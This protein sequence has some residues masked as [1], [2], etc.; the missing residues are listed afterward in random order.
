MDDINSNLNEINVSQSFFTFL[1]TSK[2]ILISTNIFQILSSRVPEGERIINL[3]QESFT[4]SS[5][6]LPKNK[7]DDIMNEITNIRGEWDGVV[8]KIGDSL[9]NLK[10]NINRWNAMLENKKRLN[11]WL[12]EKEATLQSIPQGNGEISEMKTLLDRLKYLESEIAQK[13]SEIDDLNLEM[14]FFEPLG[15]PDEDKTKLQEIVER[16]KILKQNCGERMSEF[17]AEINDYMA[18][19]H[20]MQEIEKWLLQISFQLMAHNS[21]YISNYEQTKEQI[22]QHESL[23]DYIQK[24]QSNIDDLDA[25]GQQQIK[26]YEPFSSTVREKIEGQI[27]NIQESYNS[28][29]HTSIQIKNRL[30]D[31]LSKFK[32][33]E[34]TLDSILQNLDGFEKVV[35]MEM[36]KPLITLNEAKSQLQFM[37][38]MQNKLQ[39]E[40]Q[41]LVLACQAC[42]AA[43]ASISRPSSPVFN[44]SPQIPEK[45]LIVRAKLDDLV[46]KLL[47]CIDSLIHKVKEFD[48]VL[49]KRDD[50]NDWIEQKTIFAGDIASKPSKLRPES[51]AQD[52]QT[53]NDAI[54]SINQKRN[55]IVTEFTNQLPDEEIADL[56]KRLDDLESLLMNLIERKRNNQ[57]IID[58]YLKSISDTKSYFDGVVHRLEVIE[59]P[60]GKNCEQ[61]L[62]DIDT[63]KKEFETKAPQLRDQ[64][65]GKSSNVFEVISNLDAQ[66]VDDHLKAIQRR[67]NDIKKKIERKIQLMNLTNKNIEKLQSEIDQTKFFLEDNIL[68]LES[69]FVLGYISKPIEGYL[70]NLKNL[71]KDVENKQAFVESLNK[72]VANMHSE[73]DSNEQQKLKQNINEL[74]KKEKKLMD[75]LKAEN[76]RA[77]KG[78]N[79]AREVEN[80]IDI[81]RSWIADQK[82]YNESKA[83]I[84]SFSPSAIDYEVQE[85][86]KRLQDI[87]E[88][89]DSVLSDTIEQISIIKEQCDDSGKD[90]IQKILDNFLAEIQTLT[91]SYNQQLDTIQKILQ[92]KKEYE[93]DSEGLLNWIKEIEAIISSNVKTSSIQILEEQLRKYEA[94]LKEAESKEYVLK[95]VQEKADQLVEN[96]SEVDRLNLMCQV[97]NLSDKFNLLVLKLKERQNGIIDNIRQLKE[98]QK[99]ISEYTQFILSIQQAIRELN[100]PIGSKTEDVQNL[101]KEYENILNKLKAKKA[102]MSMQKISSLPQIKELLSTHDDIIEAIENQL[103]RLK[104]LLMLREQ[105]IALVNEI[106]NFNVKYTDIVAHV[107]KSDDKIENKIK[108]Y[109]KIMLKIQECEGL[110]ASAND[111]GMQIASEGTVEDRNNI[112]EQLQTLKQQLQNLKQTV[113]NLRQQYEKAANLYKN[114]E[115]DITKTINALH[116]KEAAIKILPIL[117]INSESV[118][119]E[120]RKHDVLAKDIQKL[121]VKLQTSID[122]IENPEA[123]PPS[124]AETVSIGRTLLRSLPK[125]VDERKKYLDNNRDYRLD[126]IKLVSEFKNWIDSVESEFVGDND[127]IDFENVDAIM[128]KHVSCVDNKL[129]DVKQLLEKINEVGKNILPSLN[130]INKEELLRDLQKFAATFKDI[131]ARAEQSKLNLEKNHDI[132]KSYCLLLQSIGQLLTKVSKE[133]AI[134]STDK[135]REFLQKLNT[136][137]ATIQV[138]S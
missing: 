126:Y 123:L 94:F 114:F 137:L 99:Q 135:L 42:E 122:G 125:E 52:M 47:P 73:L 100:K 84:V 8:L 82:A 56:E 48:E 20:Q 71:M 112:I 129:H 49:T 77:S 85:Y 96:L 39:H 104:Q 33:Y 87:K 105:F 76:S 11:N 25:K 14:K 110:F 60:C 95:A 63:I 55:I 18:Y 108:Q 134:S 88:F 67:E 34:D 74:Q 98:A 5:N 106:V 12:Q 124:V 38:S 37:T 24:Y 117:D 120:L 21:L 103:R 45:E 69:L 16:F 50:L 28:L 97:K 131:T 128:K 46:D 118:E 27:K 41:R 136:K 115:I 91:S 30:Y 43:T 119:Q 86:K 93:Q 83:L 29:L 58:D 26:R 10:A 17:E 64:I 121:L 68:K 9:N 65:Q 80:N 66:Q 22:V 2:N 59:G 13:N 15:A 44:Q 79:N 7:Q 102:E 6:Y 81:V 127:D 35:D 101:L 132:W 133:E 111:K 4:K 36:E 57:G 107:E 72:R 78:L 70:Q 138:S 19:Q 61:K 32:E 113:E 31:S 75:L 130:N 51:A 62:N 3:M 54:Q 90:E 23:L 40:K 1:L 89:S 109:D 53:I 116:E 92:K